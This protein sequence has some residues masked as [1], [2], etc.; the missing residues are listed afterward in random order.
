MTV[1][2]YF[3]FLYNYNHCSN[4]AGFLHS[5]VVTVN[6][7]FNNFVCLTVVV[8]VLLSACRVFDIIKPKPP[9]KKII[10]KTNLCVCKYII[11]IQ[12]RGSYIP[13]YFIF[14]FTFKSFVKLLNTTCKYW[15]FGILFFPSHCQ[16]YSFC[17]FLCMC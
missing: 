7:H 15:Y 3:F 2:L 12:W 17:I 14:R 8:L 9:K 5:T 6:V 16:Y 4:T 10:K 11:T 1:C 13:M